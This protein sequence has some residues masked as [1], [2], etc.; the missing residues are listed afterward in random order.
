MIYGCQDDTA[1]GVSM[2]SGGQ[3]Q[4]QGLHSEARTLG[5]RLEGIPML[6]GDGLHC[7]DDKQS[8]PFKL[9]SCDRFFSEPTRLK[10]E[11]ESV[12]WSSP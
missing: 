7:P 6:H 5:T 1:T 2:H 9:L 3:I 8:I 12:T 10:R 11:I 4:L